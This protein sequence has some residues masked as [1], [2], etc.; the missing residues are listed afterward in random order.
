MKHLTRSPDVSANARP[1]GV[2]VC[3][4]IIVDLTNA[5]IDGQN[6][7]R[8]KRRNLLAPRRTPVAL[9]WHYACSARRG[10]INRLL[11]LKDLERRRSRSDKPYLCCRADRHLP[12]KIPPC[13]ED[14]G[15]PASREKAEPPRLRL[16]RNTLMTPARRQKFKSLSG[17]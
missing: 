11:Q 2:F 8:A 12:D 1:A 6:G 4:S 14:A 3:Y 5:I 13:D 10:S 16:S 7:Q 15:Y 9:P 17:T